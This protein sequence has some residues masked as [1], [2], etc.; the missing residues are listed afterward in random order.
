MLR[1][2]QLTIDLAARIVEV[3]ENRLELPAKEYEL[4]RTLARE[5]TRVLTKVNFELRK[6]E[7]RG[8][9]NSGARAEVIPPSP[10]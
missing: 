9:R 6:A 1:V 4:L 5:P 7:G 3:E 10:Q 2:G 8:A